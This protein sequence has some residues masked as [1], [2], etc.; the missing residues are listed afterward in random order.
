MCL[1]A[2][3]R[4]KAV[5]SCSLV[6][7]L[8]DQESVNAQLIRTP[9]QG[10]SGE[11]AASLLPSSLPPSLF[12]L[13]GLFF[14]HSHLS[15]FLP[16][17]PTS[18]CPSPSFFLLLPPPHF[19]PPTH[20]PRLFP[21]TPLFFCSGLLSSASPCLPLLPPTPSSPSVFPRTSFPFTAHCSEIAVQ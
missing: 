19:P 10:S 7:C 21:L 5:W 6:I 14:F 12:L 18:S 9:G 11:L 1:S 15:L 16:A 17:C 8:S 20:P 4:T 2:V 13:P 3:I